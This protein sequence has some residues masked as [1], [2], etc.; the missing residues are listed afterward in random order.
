M[1]S[2][3]SKYTEKKIK[4]LLSNANETFTTNLPNLMANQACLIALFCTVG[5]VTTSDVI[6]FSYG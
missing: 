3:A 2:P 6:W 4:G 1:Y 5:Y